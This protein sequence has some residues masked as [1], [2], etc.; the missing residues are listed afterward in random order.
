MPL[1]GDLFRRRSLTLFAEPAFALSNLTR[2]FPSATSFRASSRR[3]RAS[4]K[5]D[6]WVNAWGE[7]ILVYRR[8][9]S[10]TASSCFPLGSISNDKPC[11]SQAYRGLSSGLARRICISFKGM[12]IGSK[13]ER[14]IYTILYTFC[15]GF[16]W[17]V[18]DNDGPKSGKIVIN[19]GAYG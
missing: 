19:Q 15:I 13:T 9:D 4:A 2:F 12:C 10:G 17:M 5:G 18:T 3:E 11:P 16:Y 14:N 1:S 6:R 8:S 7:I